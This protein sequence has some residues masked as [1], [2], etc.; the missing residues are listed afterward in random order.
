MQAYTSGAM[1]R[2]VP[3]HRSTREQALLPFPPTP[4]DADKKL[5]Q[6]PTNETIHPWPT[7][8]KNTCR[9]KYAGDVTK[10]L[11]KAVRPRDT[12]PVMPVNDL[13]SPAQEAPAGTLGQF[14][15]SGWS[16][17]RRKAESGSSLSVLASKRLTPK[18]AI[19]IHRSPSAKRMFPGF[20]SL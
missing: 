5:M 13:C 3:G 2:R 8:T 17:G 10:L 4:E 1:Y 14:R 19:F 9:H 6:P 20:K 18:S 16:S 11:G 12:V 7:N 15:Q